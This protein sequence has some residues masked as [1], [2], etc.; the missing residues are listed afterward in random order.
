MAKKPFLSGNPL[1]E[2]VYHSNKP[3]FFGRKFRFV[4]PRKYHAFVSAKEVH[5]TESDENKVIEWANALNE[6]IKAIDTSKPRITTDKKSKKINYQPHTVGYWVNWWIEN[7]I[8]K[9]TRKQR[10]QENLTSGL[11]SFFETIMTLSL[12]SVER[13]TL[14]MIWDT[15][16]HAT[17][18]YSRA[19]LR[20]FTDYLMQCGHLK[21]DRNPFWTETA[22]GFAT[23]DKPAKKRKI[24]S[25]EEL[26]TL[27]HNAPPIL[28]D[29]LLIGLYTALRVSDVVTIKFTDIKEI[30]GKRYL[31]KIVQKSDGM[32]NLKPTLMSFDLSNPENAELNRLLKRLQL[33]ANPKCSSV[34]QKNGKSLQTQTIQKYFR[35]VWD[36]EIGGT[37]SSFHELR[38]LRLA[39]EKDRKGRDIESI[40]HALGHK[41]SK[42]TRA[43]YDTHTKFDVHNVNFG[44]SLADIQSKAN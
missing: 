26:L 35:K 10:T 1:P 12:S 4:V 41:D 3:E 38:A 2:N 13:S 11:N 24:L 22:G 25:E 37:R 17:Q 15:K 34:I 30:D 9:S 44:I 29:A 23:K 5:I 18:R 36:L 28:H 27:L 14:F 39:I 20:R 42:V 31:Q 7:R 33:K 19:E 6:Q 16:T 43:A 8:K 21:L 32:N 40:A